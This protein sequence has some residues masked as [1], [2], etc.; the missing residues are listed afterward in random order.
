MGIGFR[1]M[2]TLARS[3]S[4]RNGLGLSILPELPILTDTRV[5]R[6]DRHE[7]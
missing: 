7:E 5:Q 1:Q 3:F 4:S 6:L 2:P